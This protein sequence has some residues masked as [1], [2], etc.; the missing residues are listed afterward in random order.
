MNLSS[1]LGEFTA[2]QGVQLAA[3]LVALDVVLGVAAALKARTF[4]FVVLADFLRND[5]LGKLLPY[6]AVWAAV[7]VGG[8]W[9]VAGLGAI[10]TVTNAAVIAALAASVL[11]SLSE[12]GLW[13]SAPAVVAAP[14]PNGADA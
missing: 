5:V 8:D 9:Q 3:A 2:D 4:R 14:D 1:L 13:Q 12:L 7:R 11:N 6:F 10:E